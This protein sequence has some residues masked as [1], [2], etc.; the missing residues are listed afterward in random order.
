[1][2]SLKVCATKRSSRPIIPELEIIKAKPELIPIKDNLNLEEAF[3]YCDVNGLR[4]PNC[5]VGSIFLMVVVSMLPH[6]EFGRI[7]HRKDAPALICD[8]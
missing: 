3:S 2:K 7:N 5:K 4:L 8:W 6:A 1:M